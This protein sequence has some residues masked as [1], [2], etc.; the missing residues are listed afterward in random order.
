MVR[1]LR[2]FLVIFV[3]LCAAGGISRA[4]EQSQV[5]EELKALRSLVERQ[6]KQIDELSKRTGAPTPMPTVTPAAELSFSPPVGEAAPPVAESKSVKEIVDDYLNEKK[7]KDAAEKKEK[8]ANEG[9]RLGTDMGVTAE[10]R[11]GLFLWLGTAN[12][13]FTM[14]PGLWVQYDNVAYSQSPAL[15]TP[16]GKF[17]APKGGPESGVAPGGIGDLEDGTYFRRVFPYFEGT[18]WDNFEYRFIFQVSNAQFNTVG[19]D[20]VWAGANNIPWLGT[21]RLGHIKTPMG[22]EGDMTGSSRTMTFMER[23]AY[24]ESIEMNQNFVTGLL[25]SNNYL[26]QR[27]TFTYAAFRQDIASS[28]GIAFGDGQFGLQGRLTA[29]P[30]WDCDGRTWLH[31]GLSGGWRNGTN[32]T[33]GANTNPNNPESARVFQLRARPELRDDDPAASP[34]GSQII[35]D[36]DSTRM[37]DTGVIVAQNQFVMGT[38]LC[39]VRGPFSIQ[40]E[41]G[42]NSIDGATGFGAAGASAITK[43]AHPTDYVFSGGYAQLA[44][45][46]TGESRSYNKQ[47]GI[48]DRPYFGKN[49]PFTNAWFVRDEDGHL[50]WGLGAWEIAARYSYVNLNDGSGISRVQGGVMSGCTIALNW[51]LS[52]NMAMMFDYVYDQRYEV[53]AATAEGNVRGFG[54]R[55]QFQF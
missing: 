37:I 47:Y 4:Q 53:P 32:N 18:V 14:H 19:L 48:L 10:F 38:E 6:Q 31:L 21:V 49:G 15:K 50:S 55:M 43:L 29:L 11:D 36:S 27:A 13:D 30:I 52:S 16:A 41:Y 39:Y 7:E 1:F 22:F 44:Y 2:Q 33:N 45:T 12:K 20:E 40:A 28:T 46:L 5:I 9:Y 26:D 51:Y 17:N 8:L 3:V 34:A 23:S 35:P 42:L 24:S 54:M 25:V